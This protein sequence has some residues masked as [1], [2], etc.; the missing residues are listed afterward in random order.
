MEQVRKSGL[1]DEKASEE[2]ENAKRTKSGL[3]RAAVTNDEPTQEGGNQVERPKT[4]RRRKILKVRCKVP[5]PDGT[6]EEI[7]EVVVSIQKVAEYLA[8][9]QRLK[10]RK[11]QRVEEGRGQAAGRRLPVEKPVSLA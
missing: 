2:L 1:L 6:E 7:L 10:Q 8:R 11:P 3:E 5:Q 9:E 4:R